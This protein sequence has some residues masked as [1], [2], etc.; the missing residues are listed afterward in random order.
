M[1]AEPDPHLAPPL[2]RRLEIAAGASRFLTLRTGAALV[3][4]AGS[5]RVEESPIAAEAA[6]GLALPVSIRVNA[7]ETHG[8]GYGGPV[9]VTA[10]GPA[11]VICLD[12]PGP[13]E[14]FFRLAANIFR[15]NEPENTN[16]RLGALHKI[17]K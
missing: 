4:V 11:E 6:N 7:G 12:V 16:N 13:L 3:C 1:H 5:V 2:T 15:M 10:I 14:R 9:R 17:S 8:V